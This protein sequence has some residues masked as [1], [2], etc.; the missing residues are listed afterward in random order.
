[1]KKIFFIFPLVLAISFNIAAQRSESEIAL[2]EYFIDAEFFLAQ[3]YYIDALSDFLQVYKRGYQNNANVNYRIGICYL[4]IPGQKDKSIPYFEVAKQSISLKYKESSLKEKNAPIDVYLYL[5]NAYRVNNRLTEAIASYRRYKEML[6][7]NEVNLHKYVD[8][9]IEAC[10]IASDFMSTP[11]ELEFVNLGEPINS[12]NDDYKAVIS[13]DGNTLLYMHRLP[14]YDAVYY[15]VK[16]DGQWSTPENITPQLMSDGNQYVTDVSYDGKT[17]LLTKEDEFNSDIYISHFE[18]NRWTVSRPLGSNINTKYWE[19]HAC[20]SK[21]GKILYF[22]SNRNGGV[23]E[24]DIYVSEL[25]PEGTF[26]PA[27]NVRE[28]NTELNEDTPFITMDGKQLF[29]SSQG[30]VNMGGYDVFVSELGSDNKWSVPENMGYPI[31]STDD[32]LFYYP[33]DNN[34]VGLYSRIDKSGYGGMDIFEVEYPQIAEETPIETQPGEI[35]ASADTIGMEEKETATGSKVEVKKIGTDTLQAQYDTS[36]TEIIKTEVKPEV[37]TIE[38]QPVFFGFDKTALTDESKKE[39]IKVFKILTTY[40]DVRVEIIGYADPLGPESYN[41]QLSERRARVVYN[42]IM[43]QGI[44]P[45]RLEIQGKGE[46]DFI[47]INTNADGT[48]SPEG[49][50]YNRRAEF[51][52]LKVDNNKLIIQRIDPVPPELKIK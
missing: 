28:L 22:T 6:P 13:G 26:G 4:N 52:F 35:I 18:D 27:K 17:L 49:R 31:S 14:F 19:S 3:E 44:E 36:K 23:G 50:K 51:I 21:D 1:M 37:R 2:R 48:D 40:P 7:E 15:S 43:E 25:T 9:Q 41:L 24:M 30:Y 8:K 46:T 38:V 12:S 29:F 16:V 10:N 11:D 42:F 47:A 34:Q 5:G 45:E 20:L 39:L 32:D 33:I